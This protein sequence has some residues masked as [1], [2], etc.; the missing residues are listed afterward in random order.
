MAGSFGIVEIQGGHQGLVVDGDWL[1]VLSEALDVSESGIPGHLSRF[2]ERAAVG[3]AA[4]QRRHQGRKAALGFRPEDD[5]EMVADFLHINVSSSTATRSQDF[6]EWTA[7]AAAVL[8]EGF[9]RAPAKLLRLAGELSLPGLFI[10]Q[11]LEDL[12]GDG[13]LLLLGECPDLLQGFF[14]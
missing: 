11:G 3:D 9:A 1:P 14:K 13:V 10:L 12:G 6:V 7:F 5:V 2:S 4:G 8:L